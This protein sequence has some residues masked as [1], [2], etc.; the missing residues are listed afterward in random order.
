MARAC[1]GRIVSRHFLGENEL[2]DVA[3]EGFDAYLLAKRRTGDAFGP[4]RRSASASIRAT[5]WYFRER[6]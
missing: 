3:V 4:A 2:F 6:T 5:F 1:R